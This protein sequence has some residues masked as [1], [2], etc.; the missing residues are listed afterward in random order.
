MKVIGGDIVGEAVGYQYDESS[1][2]IALEVS[3]LNRRSDLPKRID[4]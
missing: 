3:V 2:G 4:Y 1:F